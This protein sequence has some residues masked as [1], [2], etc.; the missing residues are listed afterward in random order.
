M[1]ED[2]K[3]RYLICYDI[4]D[5]IKRGKL[6]NMLLNYGDR[7]QYSVFEADLSREDVADIIGRAKKY[8]GEEDSMRVYPLCRKCRNSVQS[9]GRKSFED[10]STARIV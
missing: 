8:V 9:L 6:H 7:L 5:D 4:E 3:R 1:A 10:S 2:D